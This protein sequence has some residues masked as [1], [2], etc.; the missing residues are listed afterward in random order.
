MYLSTLLVDTGSNPDRPRPG[1]LWLRNLYRVHQRLCM[2]FPSATRQQA[3]P[4]CL[5]PYRPEDF[6]QGRP[7]AETDA[8]EMADG[9]LAHVHISRSDRSGFL[10]RVEPQPGGNAVIVVLSALRP[11]WHYAF[12]LRESFDL[13]GRPVGN[14]GYLL[15]APPETHPFAVEIRVG[16]R[17]RFSLQANPT[18]RSPMTK[19][20]RQAR[21]TA[22][23]QV[24][25]PRRQLTWQPG[26]DPGPVF[27]GW[28]QQRSV[29]A[30]FKL[31]DV[32]VSR[33]GYAYINKG[34][35]SG[36]G[37]RLRSVCYHGT[38]EVTDA[39]GFRKALA[40]GIGPAKAFGF[41]LLRVELLRGGD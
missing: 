14:A 41:G 35:K 18:K 33:I 16:G 10:F 26:H 27:K 13:N 37:Q 20:Q 22:G 7:A 2:A 8:A 11:D 4:E 38:L 12:G 1:R 36:K 34:E 21:K 29:G 17:F 40:A 24:K 15:A 30:G 39:D 28:L 5:K 19:L 32:G 3:D 23:D 31:L 6:P 9:P 25:R